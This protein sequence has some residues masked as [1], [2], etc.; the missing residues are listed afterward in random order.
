MNS[1]MSICV[2]SHLIGLQ[3]ECSAVQYRRCYRMVYGEFRFCLVGVRL[4]SVRAVVWL[5]VL[6]NRV[7]R[8]IF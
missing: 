2:I 1:C 7:L 5:R 6:E 4:D 3:D 8:R